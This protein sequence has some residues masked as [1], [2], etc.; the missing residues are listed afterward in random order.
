MGAIT[1]RAAR[2]AAKL[3]KI[4]TAESAVFLLIGQALLAVTLWIAQHDAGLWVRIGTAALPFM[5]FPAAFLW[6][7]ATVPSAMLREAMA[8][9]EALQTHADERAKKAMLREEL[10][11]HLGIARELRLKCEADGEAPIAEYAAWWIELRELVD[12]QFGRAYVERLA[13][14]SGVP[15]R[16]GGGRSPDHTRIWGQLQTVSIRLGEFIRESA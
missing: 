13:D 4:D 6:K 1:S 10:G 16:W 11:K 15:P 3:A 14:S 2:E 5:L 8:E 12:S 7:L 9:I